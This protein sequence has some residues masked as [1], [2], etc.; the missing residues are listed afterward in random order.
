MGGLK[1]YMP[2]TYWTF[3]IGS[4]ANA[5]IF[6]LAGFWS[7]DEIIVGAWAHGRPLVAIIGLV[8]AF[9]TSLYM[10]RV[11]FLTF[12]GEE[13]FDTRRFKPHES[14]A[15]MSVPLVILAVGSV[16]AGFVGLPPEAG[17][18]HRFLEPI[19]TLP[20]VEAIHISTATSLT[21]AVISTIVALAGL[22]V[23]YAAYISGAINPVTTA[24]RYGPLY[25]LSFRKYYFDEIYEA[26][27]VHPL[28]RFSVFLWRVVDVKIIDGAVNGVASLVGFTAQR[29]RRAQT[30][31]VAN[32]AL[33]IALGTVIIVGIYLIVGS[34]LFR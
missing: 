34:N 7:K 27:I 11:V 28:Y 29:W 5:G 15:V 30:G 23:A 1:K 16:V 32:Y 8:A 21:F 20:G 6:P 26:V 9:F 25:Q 24:Q 2:I 31:L 10:F 18:F 19:F 14:P 13:R 22:G 3:V 12:H 17:P 4:A 33:A